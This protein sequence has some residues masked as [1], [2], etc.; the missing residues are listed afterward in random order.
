MAVW[1]LR[2]D[3]IDVPGLGVAGAGGHL[4]PS[5]LYGPSLD[6][7]GA[8]WQIGLFDCSTDK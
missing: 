2:P 1:S 5:R 4:R 7:F 6:Q 8:Y 3:R